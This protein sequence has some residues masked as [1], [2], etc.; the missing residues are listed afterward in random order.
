MAKQV[1]SPHDRFVRRCLAD[2]ELAKAF[3][4]RFL[5]PEQIEDIDIDSLQPG[6]K[7][8]F[9]GEKLNALT[10]DLLFSAPIQDHPGFLS[11]LVEHKSEGAARG[12][13]H[14]LP[15][16]MRSQEIMIMD[17]GRRNHPEKRYPLVRMLGLYHGE[18]AYAGPHT[19]GEHIDAP[20]RM[21]PP[22]W[23]EA[24]E[25]IDLSAYS[26]QD[27]LGDGK[28]GVFLLV[29]KHIYATDIVQ[30][31]EFL[32]PHMKKVEE[33]RGDDFIVTVFRYLYEAA[34]V[35][36]HEP[37]IHIAVKTFSEETGGKMKTVAEFLRD[38]GKKETRLEI[39]KLMLADKQPL[40]YIVKLTSLTMEQIK[41]L[42]NQDG[43]LGSA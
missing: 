1:G 23:K 16:Q 41:A 3:F 27:L 9:V 36:N 24:I 22:R 31:L 43:N 6:G 25:L 13:G 8:S 14:I 39:A 2:I 15:F 4:R 34:K 37:M 42:S 26:D 21:I 5:T 40:E 20:K 17:Y 12:E 18:R 29:L 38:E 30:T 7:D 11:L 19:V 28:L 32:A 10:T 35:E 33:E